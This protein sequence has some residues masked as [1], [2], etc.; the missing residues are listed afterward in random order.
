MLAFPF[1]ARSALAHDPA[2]LSGALTRFVRAV[3]TF[4][5]GRARALGLAVTRARTSGSV[6]FVQRFGSALQLT[7]H[8]HTLV[9]NGVFVGEARAD[10]A[11]PRFQALDPPQET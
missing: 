10:G 3:F 8:F 7:P 9:P 5:R 1:W 11:R 4:Q 6:T 2:L